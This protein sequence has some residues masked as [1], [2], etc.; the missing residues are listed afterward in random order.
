MTSAT[1]SAGMHRTR[2]SHLHYIPVIP[3]TDPRMASARPNP[4]STHA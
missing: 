4:G 1:I 2:V 3:Q